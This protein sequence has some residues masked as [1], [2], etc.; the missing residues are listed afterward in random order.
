[1]NE[2]QERDARE[3]V[4]ITVCQSLLLMQ[5]LLDGIRQSQKFPDEVIIFMTGV[6]AMLIDVN[7]R[8]KQANSKPE[9]EK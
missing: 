4:L 2:Q 6:N 5:E 8:I 7:E 9:A 1:M 3:D